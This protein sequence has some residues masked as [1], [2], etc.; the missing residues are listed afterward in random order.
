M[1]SNFSIILWYYHI[2]INYIPNYDIKI[3][4]FKVLYKLEAEAGVLDE[5]WGN[6][7]EVELLFFL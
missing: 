2:K 1:A 3:I 7:K 4:S 5:L 6:Y